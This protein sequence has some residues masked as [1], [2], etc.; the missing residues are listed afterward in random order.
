MH[1]YLHLTKGLVAS[2][3]VSTDFIINQRLR[4]TPKVL[5][6]EKGHGTNWLTNR[7]KG[8][9]SPEALM[10][11]ASQA[12]PPPPK[13]LLLWCSD[14]S[15]IHFQRIL[16]FLISGAISKGERNHGPILAL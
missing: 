9:L 10:A 16:K 15:I 7:K 2:A 3:R 1:K 4:L 13:F 8:G 6:F 12:A 14:T 5:S 11:Q